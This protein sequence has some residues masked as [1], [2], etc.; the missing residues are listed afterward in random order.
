[1]TGVTRTYAPVLS[2][3]IDTSLELSSIILTTLKDVS[4]ITPIPLLWTAAG[5]AVDII[6]VVQVSRPKPISL[7]IHCAHGQCRKL[8]EIKGHS[9]GSQRTHANSFTS[10]SLP[11]RM[12]RRMI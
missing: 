1:M 4:K 6:D 3:A 10:S 8:D 12:M 9:K 5:I 2:E 11:I 7:S